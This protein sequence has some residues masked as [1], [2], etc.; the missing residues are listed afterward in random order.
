[1]ASIDL[2]PNVS[3]SS[4]SSWVASEPG[5]SKPPLELVLQA[6]PGEDRRSR[7]SEAD[8]Q[9]RHGPPYDES[10]PTFDHLPHSSE[11]ASSFVNSVNGKRC[12]LYSSTAHGR[13]N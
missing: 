3:R 4:L 5:S 11:H 13:K 9:H 12:K 6:D 1:M 10:A 7:D 2:L 8:Q